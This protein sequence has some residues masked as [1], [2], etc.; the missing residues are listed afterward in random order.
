MQISTDEVLDRLRSHIG[1]RKTQRELAKHFRVSAAFMSAVLAG[2]KN[3]TENMLDAIGVKRV[4]RYEI[5]QQPAS[6]AD[7]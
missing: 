6:T 3:P 7:Q 2:H 4:E 1:P 5:A